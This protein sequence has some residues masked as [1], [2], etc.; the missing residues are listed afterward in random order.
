MSPSITSAT[1]LCTCVMF[2]LAYTL[3]PRPGETGYIPL[4][5]PLRYL[6]GTSSFNRIV[7]IWN[8]GARH[9]NTQENI[10]QSKRSRAGIN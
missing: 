6:F 3:G 1:D 8:E 7:F 5:K 4:K 2:H 9:A 10:K